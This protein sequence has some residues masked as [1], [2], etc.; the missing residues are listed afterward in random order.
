MASFSDIVKDPK[1]LE[2]YSKRLFSAYDQNRDKTFEI[3]EFVTLVNKI[4]KE[5]NTKVVPTKE[6]IENLFKKLDIDKSG[7]L[8]EKEFLR[9]TK[10]I[11]I[12]MDRLMK[13]QKG[14]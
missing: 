3:D 6:D 12:E 8:D 1:K 10:M 13:Q 9:F 4:G 11:L 14:K 5:N 2:A 7:R